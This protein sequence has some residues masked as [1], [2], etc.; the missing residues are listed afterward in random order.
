MSIHIVGVKTSKIIGDVANQ[1]DHLESD[2]AEV[3]FGA[4]S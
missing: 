3:T 2:D 4:C 1:G